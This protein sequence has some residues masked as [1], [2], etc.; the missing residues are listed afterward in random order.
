VL[1]SGVRGEEVV[2]FAE[3]NKCLFVGVSAATT[4][5]TDASCLRPSFAYFR[6]EVSGDEENGPFP[7]IVQ[8]S[9]E[10]AVELFFTFS[11]ASAFTCVGP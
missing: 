1:K 8:S 7:Q 6:V 2:R 9:L 4:V 10:L 11:S 5:T 3:F